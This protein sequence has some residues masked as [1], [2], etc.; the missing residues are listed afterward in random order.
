MPDIGLE[1]GKYTHGQNKH[2]I[3]YTNINVIVI[4][5]DTKVTV[6]LK[7]SFKCLGDVLKNQ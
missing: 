7:T 4:Y 3:I 6:F 5:V 1:H 2:K